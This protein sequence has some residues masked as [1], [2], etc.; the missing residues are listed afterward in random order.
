VSKNGHATLAA[1]ESHA[2][3][4]CRDHMNRL[5]GRLFGLVEATGMPGKQ[6]DGFK[7]VIRALTYDAQADLESTLRG[8]GNA[9]DQ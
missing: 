3:Q 1:H 7:S 8:D 9:D 6:Q 5:R 2:I 4:E